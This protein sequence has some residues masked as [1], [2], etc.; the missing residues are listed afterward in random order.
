M[1][2]LLCEANVIILLL[3]YCNSESLPGTVSLHLCC[4]V[5]G[6]CILVSWRV[7]LS[8]R[9]RLAYE[10]E[11]PSIYG[12]HAVVNNHNMG[13]IL[14]PSAN[15]GYNAADSFG[16]V[17]HGSSEDIC[18]ILQEIISISSQSLDEAQ[19]RFATAFRHCQLHRLWFR[20]FG[21]YT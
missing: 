3:V 7:F 8:E 11:E 1:A 13:S 6:I 4:V 16:L 14:A 18:D 19:M 2:I 17:N 9:K 10:M 20:C 21:I 5:V 12:G 15:F